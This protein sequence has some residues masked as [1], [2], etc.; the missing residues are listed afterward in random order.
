M[1][2]P[3]TPPEVLE[4]SVILALE[5]CRG[6]YLDAAIPSPVWAFQHWQAFHIELGPRAHGAAVREEQPFWREH[7]VAL[8]KARME[9]GT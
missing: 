2:L 8:L 5:G 1:T 4:A 9:R 6:V 7:P 3:R